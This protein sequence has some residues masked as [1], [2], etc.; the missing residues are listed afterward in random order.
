MQ[1]K[2][3]FWEISIKACYIMAKAL[4]IWI[5]FHEVIFVKKFDRI[6]VWDASFKSIN[7]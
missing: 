7:R 6:W 3:N 5:L 2:M 4:Y 1:K